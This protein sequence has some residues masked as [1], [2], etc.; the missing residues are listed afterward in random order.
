ME[1]YKV[2]MMVENPGIYKIEFDNSY[3]WYNQKKLRFRTYLLEPVGEEKDVR[4]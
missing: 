1:P 3:S 2:I 4:N